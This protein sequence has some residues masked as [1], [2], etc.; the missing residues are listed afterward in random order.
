MIYGFT[1]SPNGCRDET[2]K[3]RRQNPTSKYYDYRLIYERLQGVIEAREED[4]ILGLVS[5]L[6][7]GL[8]GYVVIYSTASATCVT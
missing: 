3:S 6:R 5:L 8:V 1:L 2:N 4:D 7:S